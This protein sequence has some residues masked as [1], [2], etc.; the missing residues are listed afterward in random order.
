MPFFF[1]FTKTENRKAKQVPSGAGGSS[2]EGGGYKEIGSKGE[3]IGN[4]MYTCM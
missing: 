3:F 1:F 4:T 2:M